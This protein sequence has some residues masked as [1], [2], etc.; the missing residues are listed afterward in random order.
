MVGSFEV[1]LKILPMK[2][3]GEG[4]DP[5][6]SFKSLWY[7]SSKLFVR[8]SAL[9]TLKFSGL[10][11]LIHSRR[12]YVKNCFQRSLVPTLSP[13]SKADLSTLSS[14]SLIIDDGRKAKAI[15]FLSMVWPSGSFFE[16]S[17]GEHNLRTFALLTTHYFSLKKYTLL[18]Y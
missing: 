5:I 10:T 18:I 4:F 9:N 3:L 8:L 6:S 17:Y 13:K 15:T 2:C 7:H 14:A 1:I 12:K 11:I 16:L